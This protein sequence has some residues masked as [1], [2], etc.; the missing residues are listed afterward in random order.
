MRN[1]ALFIAAAAAL[2]LPASLVPPPGSQTA[3]QQP[4]P[5]VFGGGMTTPQGG[6]GTLLQAIGHARG[7][8]AGAGFIKPRYTRPGHSVAH[9]QRMAQKRR[10]R[11][12]ARGQFRKAVR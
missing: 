4:G 1:R 11:L 2:A 10:N 3:A 12:R 5:R 8:N 6:I 9:G 7:S